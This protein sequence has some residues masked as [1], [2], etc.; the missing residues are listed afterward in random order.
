MEKERLAEA[1]GVWE[2]MEAWR[3]ADPGHRVALAVLAQQHP[4]TGGGEDSFDVHLLRACEDG[5]VAGAKQCLWLVQAMAMTMREAGGMEDINARVLRDAALEY[6]LT[7]VKGFALGAGGGVREATE[8]EVK[9][10]K[11][12]L[13]RHLAGIDLDKDS[14]KD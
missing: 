5:V 7:S 3:G 8:E 9:K 6:L 10:A 14:E 1:D 11:K 13:L 4:G 12:A 2:A